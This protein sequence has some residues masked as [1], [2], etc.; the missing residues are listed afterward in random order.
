MELNYTQ[1]DWTMK[2][3]TKEF[4]SLWIPPTK[5]TLHYKETK[6]SNLLHNS[7]SEKSDSEDS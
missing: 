1:E 7:L 2:L 4:Q 6:K 5:D 3:G